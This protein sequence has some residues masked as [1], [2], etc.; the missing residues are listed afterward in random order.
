M[1]DDRKCDCPKSV[2]GIREVSQLRTRC[3]MRP[4]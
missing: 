2:K 4:V 1:T 3:V